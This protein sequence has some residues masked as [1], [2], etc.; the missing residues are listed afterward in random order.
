MNPNPN[1][2][3]FIDTCMCDGSIGLNYI[4]NT[5]KH[6]SLRLLPAVKKFHLT[7][8]D[9][10]NYKNQPYCFLTGIMNSHNLTF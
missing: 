3:I 9:G 7:S 4:Y 5:D 10:M 6:I 8:R 1:Y 2:W